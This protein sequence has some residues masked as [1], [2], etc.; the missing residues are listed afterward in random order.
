M[1]TPAGRVPL[2]ATELLFSDRLGAWKTRWGIG[3]MNYL[4]PPGLY[5]IGTPGATDPVVVTANYKMSYDIV[6]SQFGGRNVW[7]LV[8]ETFGI[9]VWCAAGKG[10]F[11]TG[12]LV[13]RISET[14]LAMVISHRQLLLPM[15]G[16]VGVAAHEI[17]RRTG[18]TVRYAAIRAEDLPEFLDKG[19]VTTSAMREMTF[20]FR[21]RAVLVPVEFVMALKPAAVIML[22][23]S[24]FGA[25]LGR[26]GAG[27]EAAVAYFGAMLAGTAVAPILLPWLPGRSFSIKG[28]VLGFAWSALWLLLTGAA[29]NS[30]STVAAFLVLP[31]VSA[32]HA[33]NF[34]GCTPYTS[35]TG[36]KKEM[37]AALPAMGTA[38]LAGGILL[39]INGIL[40]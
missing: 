32:F 1:E 6:R 27:I 39:I 38:V 20:T 30:L 12:E 8:L 21:E 37:R 35:R 2:I 11:G 16:A 5:A 17:A 29:W 36:V 40:G 15:L 28:A 7:L 9:N 34:T 24:L 18:F 14:R 26:P 4:V 31:A 33:L 19:R 3:R 22:C 25:L 10:T 13:R 23:V